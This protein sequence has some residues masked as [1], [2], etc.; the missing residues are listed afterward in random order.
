MN[1]P[2]DWASAIAILAAGL[3]AGAMIIYFAGRRK[4]APRDLEAK[5]DALLQQIR[6]LQE[7]DERRRL[8][9][10]AAHVLRQLD[11]RSRPAPSHRWLG[12]VGGAAVILV[13]GALGYF[14]SQSS[15]P[16]QSQEPQPAVDSS[17]KALEANVQADPD[18][19]EARIHLARAY[20][21][22][23][24]MRGVAQQTEYVL[25]RTPNDSRA[26]TFQA[27]VLMSTG[28]NTSAMQML[29][30]AVASDPNFLD[31]Y[32]TTA[33]LQLQIG[34]GA[35]AEQTMEAA[36][37]LH[38][39]ERQRLQPLFDEIRKHRNVA[40]R[41]A[42]RISLELVSKPRTGII[43]VIARPAGVASG[44]PL[45]VKRVDANSL[46]TTIDLSDADSMI[47]EPLPD[48]LRIEARLDSDGDVVTKD[49]KDPFAMQD[50]VTAGSS[51]RLS[52][53]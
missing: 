8:E 43:Y 26:L 4:A 32:V 25:A 37:K 12:F 22:R 13:L 51:I 9:L 49:P 44:H 31:A 40:V 20:V 33:W 18:N 29:E 16:K 46:P 7:G 23:N 52:L 17:L 36:L 34:K 21:E 5:R 53:Q 10:E 45:A 38:P 42:I 15:T 28:D 1:A 41:A 6:E 47:G 2:A 11:R 27:L 14:V 35:Q 19:L 3:I 30:K 24:D 50:G 48:T 39:E